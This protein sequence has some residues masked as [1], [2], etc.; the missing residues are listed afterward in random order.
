M[1]ASGAKG[2]GSRR[3]DGREEVEVYSPDDI[4][5]RV[6]KRYEQEVSYSSFFLRR[7]VGLWPLWL[8]ILGLEV[9]LL[10]FTWRGTDG[11]GLSMHRVICSF[12]GLGTGAG[13]GASWTVLC[14]VYASAVIG[15]LALGMIVYII[16]QAVQDKE[17]ATLE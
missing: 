8:A 4:R 11:I 2:A 6:K 14:P 12:L 17:N 7:A 9:V 5:R 13:D 3:G 10:L 15:H 16:V 1:T